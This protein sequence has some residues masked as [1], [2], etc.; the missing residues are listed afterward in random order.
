M[1]KNAQKKLMALVMSFALFG[2]V[3]GIDIKSEAK[4]A[5]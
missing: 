1:Q 2:L 4:E 3:L 5:L